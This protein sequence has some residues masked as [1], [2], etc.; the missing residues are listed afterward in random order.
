M[1]TLLT[2]ILIPI[3]LL[4]TGFFFGSSMK[5]EPVK[6][7]I[8]QGEAKQ[9]LAHADEDNTQPA[10][11]RSSTTATSMLR[12]DLT[13]GEK[14]TINLFESAA[15][16]VTYISTANLKRD[17][18]T[19]NINEIPRGS[20]TGFIWDKK[21]HIVTNFHVIRGADKAYVT[22]SDGSSWTASLVGY[23]SEKDL[24]VL[25]IDAPEN[26]LQP[27]PVGKSD[28]LRVGQ[29]VLAIG[30]PF[31]LDQTLTTGII[32]ALGR[33]IE[34][35]SGEAIRNV[36]QTDA[37]INPGNSGG[38]LLD[39]K[40]ELIGVNTAIYSPSG[41]YAGIGFSIPVDAVSWIVPDLIEY[42]KVKR[43]TLG[44]TLA[45]PNVLQRIGVEGVLIKDIIDG[46]AAASAQLRPT[47][48]D[49]QNG[50]R[51]G[52]VIVGINEDEIASYSDLILVLEK[53]KVGESVDLKVLREGKTF[54]TS[55][56]LD[57]AK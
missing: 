40:G 44:I 1:N 17:Y 7:K 3:V 53:Y 54:E 12:S 26:L 19:T 56:T 2:R 18:Y 25:K 28:N 32:S 38:P 39:S 21:G 20:G 23:A 24:A 9:Y 52:D 31:G 11:T 34:A 37:A 50:V 10:Q 13:K 5:S 22:L 29:D 8:Q 4:I 15:P 46:S 41:A 48:I 14:T 6:T 57:E 49:R 30:N 43:P 33:E 42:G 47:I 45:P 16:S 55:L 35:T 36:I 51:L 27:I